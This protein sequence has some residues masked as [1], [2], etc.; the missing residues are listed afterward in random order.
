MTANVFKNNLNQPAKA[1]SHGEESKINAAAVIFPKL[2]LEHPH[3]G[4]RALFSHRAGVC[5][6]IDRFVGR[7]E[8]EGSVAA[9]IG[10]NRRLM[11]RF[12]RSS[13]FVGLRRDGETGAAVA[14]YTLLP[15]HFSFCLTTLKNDTSGITASGKVRFALR[16]VTTESISTRIGSRP[17]T[18][19]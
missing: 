11:R 7:C 6:W 8:S 4:R 16:I 3:A 12:W 15:L 5:R 9:L 13:A 19:K 2:R 17:S 1:K 18:L 14:F 10:F